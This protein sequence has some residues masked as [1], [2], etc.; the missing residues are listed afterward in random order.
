MVIAIK[1]QSARQ[2][3]VIK[4]SHVQTH[5]STITDLF[6]LED[7]DLGLQWPGRISMAGNC[8]GLVTSLRVLQAQVNQPEV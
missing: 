4:V 2:A 6:L 5:S 1:L 7:F 8:K 3:D